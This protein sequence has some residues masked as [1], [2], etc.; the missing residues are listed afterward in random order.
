LAVSSNNDDETD[1][2]TVHLPKA[3]TSS[4]TKQLK[5]DCV[6]GMMCCVCVNG[7][8]SNQKKDC[9]VLC[10]AKLEHDVASLQSMQ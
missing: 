8:A 7:V 1:I 2:I 3:I 5:N 10:V 4:T 9:N 6:N